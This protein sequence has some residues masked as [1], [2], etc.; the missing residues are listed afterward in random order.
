VGPCGVRKPDHG[1]AESFLHA[2]PRCSVALAL[3]ALRQWVG[4]RGFAEPYVGIGEPPAATA[5]ATGADR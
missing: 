3:L 1:A 5:S 4:R 2:G